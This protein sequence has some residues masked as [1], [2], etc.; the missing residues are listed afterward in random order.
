MRN[1]SYINKWKSFVFVKYLPYQKLWFHYRSKSR[2]QYGGASELD[3][4]WDIKS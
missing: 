3:K 2:D 4:F 1:I